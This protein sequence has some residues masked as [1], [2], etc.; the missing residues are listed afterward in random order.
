MMREGLTIR[1]EGHEL[2]SER[3]D[4]HIVTPQRKLREAYK[5]LEFLER[6]EFLRE[7]TRIG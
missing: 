5:R 2:L 4:A 6:S 1:R 3:R 7:T